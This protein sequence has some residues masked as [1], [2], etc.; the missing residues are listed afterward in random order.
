M[1]TMEEAMATLLTNHLTHIESDLSTMSRR[2]V[3]AIDH[4]H[5]IEVAEQAAADDQTE[6]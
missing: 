5:N 6:A 2:Q 1:D 3:R 4:L